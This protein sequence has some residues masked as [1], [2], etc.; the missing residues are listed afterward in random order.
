MI[1]PV[2]DLQ[3]SSNP[4]KIPARLV[5]KEEKLFLE[6]PALIESIPE[7][8]TL[9]ICDKNQQHTGQTR[10]LLAANREATEISVDIEVLTLL[11][12]PRPKNIDGLVFS[13]DD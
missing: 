7:G 1:S 4:N 8:T 13:K 5:L 9:T 12:L 10:T 2:F 6:V 11:G 3:I